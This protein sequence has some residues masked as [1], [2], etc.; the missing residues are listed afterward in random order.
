[1]HPALT[2]AFLAVLGAVFAFSL[3]VDG[4]TEG[5]FAPLRRFSLVFQV[6]AVG[7]AIL[8]LRPGHGSHDDPSAFAATVGHGTPVLLDVFSNS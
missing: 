2:Y 3:W 7:A 4:R 5:R 8:L 1:M 6:A